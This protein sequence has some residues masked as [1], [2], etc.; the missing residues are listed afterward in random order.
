MD[1]ELKAQLRAIVAALLS[2]LA[3]R[4]LDEVFGQRRPEDP[5]DPPITAPTGAPS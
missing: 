3:K 1:D 2:W 4:A 5:P